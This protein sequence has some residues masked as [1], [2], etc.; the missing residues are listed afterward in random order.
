[1]GSALKSLQNRYVIRILENFNLFTEPM[2][3]CLFH[4][5]LRLYC[6]TLMDKKSEVIN[7]CSISWIG[8]GVWIKGSLQVAMVSLPFR[9]PPLPR[10][11]L[12]PSRQCKHEILRSART[13]YSPVTSS[14]RLSPRL[15]QKS[16]PR[17]ICYRLLQDQIR[18]SKSMRKGTIS[19]YQ[20][21][22]TNDHDKDKDKYKDK[23]GPIPKNKNLSINEH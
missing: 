17:E 6:R 19:I 10:L 13:S 20:R 23:D 7:F 14:Y 3:T 21:V 12:F 16:G 1:M 9:G 22:M 15:Q 4:C 18:P 11:G 2:V 5:I 8:I